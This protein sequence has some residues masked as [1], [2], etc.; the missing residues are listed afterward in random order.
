MK[1][2]CRRP[3]TSMDESI[4][5]NTLQTICLNEDRYLGM[6]DMEKLTSLQSL[7]GEEYEEELKTRSNN[8]C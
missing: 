1:F 2:I 8:E 3:G 7:S 4:G 5:T 6:S